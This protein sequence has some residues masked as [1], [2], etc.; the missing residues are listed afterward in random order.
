VK[1]HVKLKKLIDELKSARAAGTLTA[2]QAR[3]I[4]AEAE[5]AADHD[6]RFLATFTHNTPPEL[7]SGRL[8]VQHS[9][10]NFPPEKPSR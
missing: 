10:M 1:D 3:R 7:S 6:P 5:V 8:V 2:T 9:R 4:R